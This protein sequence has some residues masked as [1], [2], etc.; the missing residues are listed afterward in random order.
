MKIKKGDTVKVITGNDKG[1]TGEVLQVLSK[2]NKVVVKG[3][4]VK[5]KHRKPTQS[6]PEG[7]I[8]EKEAPIDASNVVFYDAKAKAAV[9]LAIKSMK[10]AKKSGLIKRQEILSTRKRRSRGNRT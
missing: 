6:V 7:S 3:V 10:K 5:I 9:R 2:D 4:N 1:A 8:V